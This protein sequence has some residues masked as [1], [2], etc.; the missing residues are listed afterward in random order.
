MTW[1]LL[2]FLSGQSAP[3]VIQSFTTEQSCCQAGSILLE[4]WNAVGRAADFTCKPEG[5][6]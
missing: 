5:N 6:T 1:V 3:I 4:E 2:F